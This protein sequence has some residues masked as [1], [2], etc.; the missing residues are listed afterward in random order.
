VDVDAG[1]KAKGR[2]M[3]EREQVLQEAKA[4]EEAAALAGVVEG[5]DSELADET[6]RQ[7]GVPTIGI[8]ASPNCDGQVLVTDDMLGLF[9]WTP[10]F[11]RRYANLRDTIS[12]AAETYANDVRS[13]EFPN[14][15]EV[16]KLK[17][18]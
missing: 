10:R 9:D 4:A 1:F 5:L 16:Y 11:D 14:S 18:V 3:D 12:R 17:V 13:G 15:A 6:T 2:F 7:V 8:G